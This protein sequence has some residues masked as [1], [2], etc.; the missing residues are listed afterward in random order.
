MT[1]VQTERPRPAERFVQG[2]LFSLARIGK[3]APTILDISAGSVSLGQQALEIFDIDSQ[4]FDP[5]V[6]CLYDLVEGGLELREILALRSEF[7]RNFRRQI[8]MLALALGQA[9]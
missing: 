7:A 9:L 4:I 5:L 8:G 6:G 3:L 2:I 1:G